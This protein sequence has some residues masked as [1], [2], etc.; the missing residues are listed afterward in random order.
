MR[1]PQ[2]DIALNAWRYLLRVLA[3]L[4]CSRR[5]CSI[6]SMS[7]SPGVQRSVMAVP[8]YRSAASGS[9][10]TGVSHA[11]AR[12]PLLT[13]KSGA[14]VRGHDGGRAAP[15]ACVPSV[16]SL[17]G[18]TRT[19]KRSTEGPQALGSK[20]PSLM[21]PRNTGVRAL[22]QLGRA[23]RHTRCFRFFLIHLR[24]PMLFSTAGKA[25]P[26]GSGFSFRRER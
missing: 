20:R 10:G 8:A 12:S 14:N 13:G 26:S 18:S 11:G 16:T 19:R 5:D 2:F 3:A 6:V 1:C 21:P 9:T 7:V 17:H 22:A 25:S 15:A 4:R 23:T 24:R